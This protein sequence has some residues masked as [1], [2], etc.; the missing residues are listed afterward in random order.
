MQR[1]R[2]RDAGLVRRWA[3]RGALL[4]LSALAAEARAQDSDGDTVADAADA[5]P[6]D[7][8]RASVSFYPSGS[9][10]S[11]L[12]FEDQWPLT[13]DVDYNDVVLRVHYRI[14]RH[15][16]GNVKTLL[17]MF[18]PVAL[19]GDLRSGLGLQL[20]FLRAGNPVTIARRVGGGAWS[21]LT[22]ETTDSR[23]TV[24]LS[25]DLRELYTGS[26]SS[27]VPERINVAGA[28]L[29]GARLEVEVTFTAA[30][31]LTSAFPFAVDGA[32][33]ALDR[34]AALAPFDV[35]IFRAGTAH[36]TRHEVHFPPFSGT[37][38]MDVSLFGRPHDGSNRNADGRWFLHVSGTPAALNLQTATAYPAEGIDIAAVFPGIIDFAQSRGASFRSF[39]LNPATAPATAA[40]RRS[41]TAQALPTRA[42]RCGSSLAAGSGTLTVPAISGASPGACAA[43]SVTNQSGVPLSLSLSIVGANASNFEACVPASGACGGSLAHGASCSLGVRLVA[44]AS[45]S[46]AAFAVIGASGSAA[47]LAH[48]ASLSAVRRLE[49]TASIG[50][51]G[52]SA[53]TAGTTCAALRAA[54]V[55]TSGLYWIDPDGVGADTPFQAWCDMTEHGGGWTLLGAL[56]KTQGSGTQLF[57]SYPDV[58]T[59]SSAQLTPNDP[60]TSFLYQ[61]SLAAFTDVRENISCVGGSFATQCL[62][63]FGV[64]FT[65]AQLGVVR[66]SWGWFGQSNRATFPDCH[67]QYGNA[68]GSTVSFCS[69]YAP[70][71]TYS[72]VIG[73]AVDLA[74]DGHG[75]SYCWL[76]RGTLAGTGSGLCSASQEPNGTRWALLWMR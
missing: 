22:A 8:E 70:T 72:T 25:S 18:D 35:F 34:D 21:P 42:E 20:P 33:G 56:A 24:V 52:S 55:A 37:A 68:A 69:R 4:A 45:G 19:G 9:A 74:R 41:F 10:A 48:T 16:N 36:P 47:G 61:G 38:S 54:G 58:R 64:G 15:A 62:Q 63:A 40:Q 71:E 23:L 31:P 29:S 39:Y 11:L 57:T 3:S 53:A 2:Y 6:C 51:P 59:R 76:G 73:W 43:L 27:G 75:S 30:A 28:E 66:A 12:S 14:E 60:P 46:F 5:F 67:T 26:T 49:G 13:T 7:P 50:S 44:S 32:G 1:S 17:A 65:A